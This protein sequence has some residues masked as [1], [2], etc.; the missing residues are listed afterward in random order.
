MTPEPKPKKQADK[1]ESQNQSSALK[2]NDSKSL[3]SPIFENLDFNE[4]EQEM[5]KRKSQPNGKQQTD[6]D[7]MRLRRTAESRSA[8]V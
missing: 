4:Y 3:L 5:K 8:N 6:T 1:F 2:A 7:D